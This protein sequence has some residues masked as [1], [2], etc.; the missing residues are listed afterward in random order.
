M[1]GVWTQNHKIFG[2]NG[3]S[4]PEKKSMLKTIF[5]ISEYVYTE[6]LTISFQSTCSS[7]GLNWSLIDAND[8]YLH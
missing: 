7:N 4:F 8:G 3:S 5:N 2:W 1:V 6:L